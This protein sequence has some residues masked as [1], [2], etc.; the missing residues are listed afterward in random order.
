MQR[1]WA[2]GPL[3]ADEFLTRDAYCPLPT[4][5]QA[6]RELFL[7]G[8][9]TDSPAHAETHPAI[10]EIARMPTGRRTHTRTS[11]CHGVPGS[12]RLWSA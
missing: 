2:D 9:S 11:C 4:L 3:T 12:E 6:A 7:D 5:V 1:P 8:K 10:D